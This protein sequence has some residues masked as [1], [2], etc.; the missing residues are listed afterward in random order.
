MEAL[1][2]EY[3]RDA[4]VS[5]E[6][7]SPLPL[8]TRPHCQFVDVHQCSR[9]CHLAGRRR[10]SDDFEMPRRPELAPGEPAPGTGAYELLD[11]FGSPTR[12]RINVA[13]GEP[14]PAARA[15]I[16][17]SRLKAMSLCESVRK[18]DPARARINVL[19]WQTKVPVCRG[20]NGHQSG[21][22]AE[23]NSLRH[24]N[25]VQDIG[26]WPRLG[27]GS[28]RAVESTSAP[29]K[30]STNTRSS[31]GSSRRAGGSGDRQGQLMLGRRFIVWMTSDRPHAL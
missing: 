16:P 21:P 19:I 1:I 7:K 31:Q 20:P 8:R 11:I 4:G 17:G 2:D 29:S 10:D 26:K 6:G 18:R 22:R 24:I 23:R 9:H 27:A 15:G 28:H 13:Q 12:V 14:L 5:V 25:A 30:I 3:I